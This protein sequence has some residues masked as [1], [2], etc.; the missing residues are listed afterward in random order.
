MRYSSFLFIGWLALFTVSCQKD[1][2]RTPYGMSKIYM[3]QAIVQ[4][5]GV[6]NN[7]SVPSGTDSSTYNYEIDSKTSRLNVILGANLSG[8][9]AGAYTVG[10]QADDDSV[11]RLL[12]AGVF[13]TSTYKL[14]PASMYTLPAQLS[15]PAGARGGTFYLGLDIGMLK[16]DSLA[17]KYLLLAV[18]IANPSLYTLD[19]ALS[20]T[21]VIV[22]VNSLVIGPAVNVTGAYIQNA[23]NPFQASAMAGSQWGSLVAWNVNP[24]AASH[25]GLGGYSTD[26]DGQTMDLES[27]WGSPQIYN[28][29]IW[30]TLDL[31][32]GT[33]GYD[34]SGGTWK[35]Q[36]TL[37]PTY[38]VTVIGQ[39]TLPDY[40][41]IAGNSGIIYQRIVNSPQPLCTFTLTA[42]SKVTVGVVM[43]YVQSGQGFKATQVLLYNYPK[44]L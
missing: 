38:I 13:D 28:G 29:K 31:P 11:R 40:S 32:A 17:G 25:S 16:A 12:A 10:V 30:Q 27:G 2:S 15:V 1:D 3:P 41:N 9:A 19:T 43:N 39:D 34:G 44:H 36:G 18:R 5:G 26:G 22:N 8:P 42:P 6:N 35:W 4:S 37:D 23:G 21:L 24:A 20:T 14:M 33:Y 7:Y